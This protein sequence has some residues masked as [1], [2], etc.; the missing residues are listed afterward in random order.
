M[1]KSVSDDHLK[2]ALKAALIEV[3]EER[4]DLIRDLVEEALEDI[5][6]S[7]AI[8][9]GEATEMVSRKEV[10]GQLEGQA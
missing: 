1:S 3:L 2:E 6:L 5:A 7:R 9:E 10:F 4:G 8:A